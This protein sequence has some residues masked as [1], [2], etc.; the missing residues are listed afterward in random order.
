MR[1][2]FIVLLAVV[3]SCTAPTTLIQTDLTRQGGVYIVAYSPNADVRRQFE[4][5][6]ASDLAGH[7]MMGFVSYN[8]VPNIMQS[9]PEEI[10]RFANEHNAAAVVVV[11]QVADSVVSNPN[12]VTPKHPTVEAFFD[13][14]RE[15]LG[16]EVGADEQVVA[17]VNGF[18][19][20]GEKSRLVWSGASM[21]FSGDGRGTAIREISASVAAGL[22][23]ASEALRGT[24]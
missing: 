14:A 18:L 16:D 22:K 20:D 13:S 8:D 11:N 24:R 19:V 3:V 21:S 5:Q 17:E 12:R 9:S 10:V 2:S 6:L 15:R 23:Q 1:G 4:D 7:D